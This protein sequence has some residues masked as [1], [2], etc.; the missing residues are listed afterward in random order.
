LYIDETQVAYTCVL[1]SLP[2][3]CNENSFPAKTLEHKQLHKL[4]VL[5]FSVFT[6]T[7]T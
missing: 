1:Y 3:S 2:F 4:Q 5:H 7:V 6:V